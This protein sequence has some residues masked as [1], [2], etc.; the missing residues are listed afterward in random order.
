VQRLSC[1]VQHKQASDRISAEELPS[2]RH[3][4]P[5]DVDEEV[6]IVNGDLKDKAEYKSRLR[7]LDNGNVIII[8]DNSYSGSF[9][10]TLIAARREW[11]C[12]WRR[13]PFYLAFEARDAIEDDDEKLSLQSSKAILSDIFKAVVTAWDGF[14]DHAVT[15]MTILEDKIYDQPA[16]ESR[17]PEL[18]SN[19]S[20]WL[21]MEKLLNVHISVMHEM[22]MRLHEL[23]GTIRIHPHVSLN[24]KTSFFFSR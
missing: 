21:K 8:F 20:S 5:V 19:S 11:E 18:W 22:K 13:L 2:R 10:D 17:A 6:P 9:E 15:H 12:R 24:T 3:F 16:D 1:Y 7:Y 14:L 4:Y 23:T